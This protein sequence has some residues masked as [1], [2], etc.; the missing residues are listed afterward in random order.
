MG[1][2]RSDVY[3]SEKRV[4][5]RPVDAKKVEYLAREGPVARL[6]ARYAICTVFFD[7]SAAREGRRFIWRERERDRLIPPTDREQDTVDR[8]KE[9]VDDR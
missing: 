2:T 6:C 1:R 9:N 4:E 7:W 8:E 3:P 5:R